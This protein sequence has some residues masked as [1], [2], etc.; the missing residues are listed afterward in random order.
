[1][2]NLCLPVIVL[3][4]LAPL[5]SSAAEPAK[6]DGKWLFETAKMKDVCQ[7][8]KVW[9]SVVT[10]SG[11]TFT[12]PDFLGG[13]NPLTGKLRFDAKDPSFVDLVMDEFD[14]SPLGVRMKIAAESLKGLMKIESDGVATLALNRR[15]V[16]PRP[17]K[18]ESSETVFLV[19]LRRA[20]KEFQAFPKE[21]RIVVVGPDDKPLEGAVAGEY[22]LKRA[23]PMKG[24]GEWEV[25]APKSTDPKGVVV[26][27]FEKLP[28]VVRHEKSKL[29]GYPVFSPAGL[30]TGEVRVKLAPEVRVSGKFTCDELTKTG[31]SIKWTNAYLNQNGRRI[32]ECGSLAAGFDFFAV[33]GEYSIR[34]YGEDLHA[35]IFP[36]V[37]PPN[38]AEV[39][40]DPVALKASALALLRGKPAPEF[41]DVFGWAGKPVK[42][43]DLKG[44]HVLIEFWGYW[45][46][47][48]VASMPVLIELHEKYAD[49]GLV[50]I[51][52]HADGGEDEVTNAEQLK[53]KLVDTVKT[54]WKGKELPFS[55]ALVSGKREGEG[56]ERGTP[57][58]YGILG[59][60]TTILIGPDGKV[61]GSFNA[62]D[63]KAATEQ[64]DRLLGITPAAKTP[65][66]DKP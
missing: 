4:S 48:C 39:T 2:R 42:L 1:V 26:F 62:R 46:G 52:V 53:E 11:D 34:A 17:T 61:V 38:R 44:K 18:F 66:E 45:C 36:V 20:P 23:T 51:G 65:E 31:Q 32:A 40:V 28:T 30:T 24:E 63:L 37:V 19:T 14:L 54:L 5:F 27:P 43:A 59:F 3:M 64:V 9:S 25:Y 60:P 47:P 58:R 55:N 29:I 7:L 57:G 56:R 6:L 15:A 22:F 41:V 49:K 33:P 12:V 8:D 35:R 16:D 50:V 21:V 10:V 13:A